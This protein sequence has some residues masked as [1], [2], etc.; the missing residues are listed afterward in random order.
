MHEIRFFKKEK[1][2]HSIIFKG[3]TFQASLQPWADGVWRFFLWHRLEDK[4]KLSWTINPSNN[5]SQNFSKTEIQ[6]CENNSEARF[7]DFPPIHYQVDPFQLRWENLDFLS[8]H[9]H[10]LKPLGKTFDMLDLAT[11]E[12]NAIAEVN[13]GKALG[14]GITLTLKESSQRLYYGLGERTGFLNKKGRIWENWTTDDYTHRPDTDP[15]YQAHPFLMIADSGKFMGLYLDESWRTVFDLAATDPE[16]SFIHTDGPTFDLY[17]ISGPN[18]QEVIK[19]YLEL[20]GKPPL[21]PLWSL[22]YHQC[23]WSYP[24]ANTIR[25]IASEYKERKIP[26]EAIWMDIDYME[27][28]KVFTFSPSRFPEPEKLTQE[29]QN[30]GIKSVLIVDPAVK[31]EV[32]Y[33]VYESGLKEDVF[34]KNRKDENLVGEVWPNPALWPDFSQEKVRQWWGEWH[35]VYL[36]KGVSGIWNDMNEPAAFHTK[37]KT[38]P[39]GAKH[40]SLW[41]A[42]VH[43]VY[44]YL[45][46]QATYEALKKQMPQKRPFVL[47]R[48]GF[49]GIQKY[50]WV[51]TGDNS[52]YWEHL[53][54][55]IPMLLNLGISG[56]AFTGADIGG[57]SGDCNGELL[58]RWTWLGALYP[59]M[60]NHSGKGSKRQEPWAFGEPYTSHIKKAI[61][62]RYQIIPYIYT[63]AYESSQTGLPL[64][65]PLFLEYP[66]DSNTYNLSYQFLLGK[67]LLAAPATK[68]HQEKQMLYLPT[69]KW[70]N[71][72]TGE[73][74]AGEQWVLV[75]TP[76]DQVPLFQKE[77]SAIPL[78]KKAL[79]TTNALWEN[80]TWRV[81]PAE[82]IRGEIYEDEGEGYNK[83]FIQCLSGKSEKGKIKLCQSQNT[84]SHHAE[85]FVEK[86]PLKVNSEYSYNEKEKKL[87]V[88]LK[89]KEVSIDLY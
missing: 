18:P 19:R 41:H 9:S 78:T 75:D 43:N 38:L 77:G 60:R 61:E 47:T 39:L 24:D 71:F 82:K 74:L 29:L 42:Q 62:F 10:R 89:E 25:A 67:N 26:L 63:L 32:G 14:A 56:V 12:G 87:Q 31:K 70:Q 35:Q 69:G 8:F 59:F 6:H 83:G 88:L 46:C 57:F 28:Y 50:S 5:S 37:T 44:G 34:I 33:C 20:V 72:W 49:S 7:S 52:S 81:F 64:L 17:L 73:I 76:L 80:L 84:Y 53:E 54:M 1:N 55:S 85:I 58:T 30:Q 11:G 15:L 79:H 27:G 23:R 65:R 48:S 45:M 2:P 40:G 86:M 36:K 22:G 3:N 16:R 13:D 4:K 68:P 21:P 51:W 66:T